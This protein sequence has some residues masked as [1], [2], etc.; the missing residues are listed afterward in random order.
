M[1]ILA[2]VSSGRSDFAG[3]RPAGQFLDRSGTTARARCLEGGGAHRDHLDLVAGAH[4]LH[5]IAGIDQPLEG[6]GGD[7]LDDVRD[8]HHVEQRRYSRHDILARGGRRRDDRVIG[9]RERHDQR[10]DRF[11]EHMLVNVV[12]GD[13]HLLHAVELGSGFG[14][15]TARFAGDEHMHVGA[16]RLCGG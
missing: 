4:G 1:M 12:V 15:G 8:L 10:R 13:Q 11:G 3:V 7:H 6:I 2:D 16:E 5:G 9:R 14:N